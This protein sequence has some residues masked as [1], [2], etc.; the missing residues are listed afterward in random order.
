MGIREILRKRARRKIRKN[1]KVQD[2]LNLEIRDTLAMER[3]KLSNER[4]FLSYTRTAI[5]VVLGGLTFIKLFNDPIYIGLG[6]LAI[7][8]GIAFGFYGYYRFTKKRHEISFHTRSY[9]PTS[10]ILAEVE[11]EEKEDMKA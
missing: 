3:T 11:A 6:I 5:A 2:K 9:Q 8:S 1:L 10:P 4:T 7:P